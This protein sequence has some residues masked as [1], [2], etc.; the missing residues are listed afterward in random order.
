[1]TKELKSANEQFIQD[2]INTYNTIREQAREKCVQA[3]KELGGCV[4]WDWENE[5]APSITSIYFDDDLSDCYVTKAYLDDAGN[6]VVDLHAY[7][8][9]M[10]D[11]KDVLFA[12]EPNADYLELLNALNKEL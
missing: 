5:D 8:K 9:D 3:L 1:M 6:I 12:D 10:D 2:C 11:I 7:Y 4:E